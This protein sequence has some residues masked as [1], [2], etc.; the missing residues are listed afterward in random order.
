MLENY[1]GGSGA[2]YRWHDEDSKP[3][4]YLVRFEMSGNTYVAPSHIIDPE[5]VH[6]LFQRRRIRVAMIVPYTKTP[7][8]SSA[9]TTQVPV[10]E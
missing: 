6:E 1:N 9:A 8:P 2:T 7:T 5:Q 4:K 3:G 10:A